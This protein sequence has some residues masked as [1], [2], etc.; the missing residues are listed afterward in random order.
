MKYLFKEPVLTTI[1][2]DS[3]SDPIAIYDLLVS[4]QKNAHDFE[5]NYTDKQSGSLITYRKCRITNIQTVKDD[6]NHEQ[7]KISLIAFNNAANMRISNIALDDLQSICV[8]ASK[9]SISQKQ[10]VTRWQLMEVPI[11]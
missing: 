3:L 8:I 7:T 10:G 1:V 4:I 5:L 2:N 6:P 9:Q 11:D